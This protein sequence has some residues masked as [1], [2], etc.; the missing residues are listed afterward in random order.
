MLPSNDDV[1]SRFGIRFSMLARRWR[2]VL[3]RS[4]A[5]QGLTSTSWAPLVHLDEMGDGVNQKAL[6]ARLG[7]DAASLVRLLDILSREKLVERRTAEADKRARLIYL[8]PTGRQRVAHIRTIL[9]RA[10][11]KMLGDIDTSHIAQCL[12]VLEQIDAGIT[13]LH[14]HEIS[15]DIENPHD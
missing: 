3:D 12:A 15:D 5:E 2:R 4:L 9:A 1:R 11:A 13:A 14:R 6:A 8:T 10:E 7:M